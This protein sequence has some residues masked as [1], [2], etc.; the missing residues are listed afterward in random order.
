[1]GNEV[2]EADTA[3][4]ALFDGGTI[5]GNQVEWI[6]ESVDSSIDGVGV[7]RVEVQKQGSRRRSTDENEKTP[8]SCVNVW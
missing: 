6:A 2:Q 8:E 7:R 3:R 5:Y 1:V 4:D